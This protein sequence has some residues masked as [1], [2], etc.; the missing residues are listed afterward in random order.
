VYNAKRRA[1]GPIADCLEYDDV[2]HLII[3]PKYVLSWLRP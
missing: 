2:E 1:K 3:I